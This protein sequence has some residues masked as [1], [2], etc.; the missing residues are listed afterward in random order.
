MHKKATTAGVSVKGHKEKKVS[1]FIH[2]V[3]NRE[4][5]SV[6]QQRGLHRNQAFIFLVRFVPGGRQNYIV[7]G[8]LRTKAALTTFD[9]TSFS[10]K[11]CLITAKEQRA[12]SGWE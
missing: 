5:V 9:F 6:R 4:M 1:L 8:S 11:C 3:N 10:G 12:I 7:K 2:V